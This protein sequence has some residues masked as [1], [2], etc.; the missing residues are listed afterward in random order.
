MY[1]CTFKRSKSDVNTITYYLFHNFTFHSS[2]VYVTLIKGEAPFPCRGMTDSLSFILGRVFFSCC[3]KCCTTYEESVDELMENVLMN[4]NG[5]KHYGL[6]CTPRVLNLVA[7]SLSGDT[8]GY[9]RNTRT[10]SLHSHDARQDLPSTATDLHHHVA[11]HIPHTY[12][13]T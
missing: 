1:I 3:T 9:A 4:V 7:F 2:A 8:L 6:D 10:K 11:Q 13:N 5:K 12:H